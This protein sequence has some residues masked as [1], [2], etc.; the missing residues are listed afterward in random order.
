MSQEAQ[1]NLRNKKEQLKR[2]L[3]FIDQMLDKVRDKN[4]SIA[5]KWE[6]LSKLIQSDEV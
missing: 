6:Q 1:Y 3:P 4:Q 5:R 2:H